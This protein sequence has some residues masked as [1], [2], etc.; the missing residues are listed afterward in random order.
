[1]RSTGGAEG[2]K[3]RADADLQ[4]AILVA[5]AD[6]YAQKIKVYGDA[7]AASLYAESFGRDP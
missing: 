3:N 1:M 6:L 2:D 7:K 5:E 4:R